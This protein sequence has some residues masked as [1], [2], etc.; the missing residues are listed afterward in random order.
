MQPARK[1]NQSVE[2]VVAAGGMPRLRPRCHLPAQRGAVAERLERRR[3]RG[4]RAAAGRW[5]CGGPPRMDAHAGVA[6]IAPGQQRRARRAAHR[7]VGV[8][9]GEARALRRQ[10]VEVRRAEIGRAHARQVA[11]A[12]VVGE[13]DDEVGVRHRAVPCPLRA[14]PSP[15]AGTCC[16]MRWRSA[17]AAVSAATLL[18]ERIDHATNSTQTAKTTA[19]AIAGRTRSFRPAC[20]RA[21][22][23]LRKAERPHEQHQR[24]PDA[25]RIA[26]GRSHLEFRRLCR[27]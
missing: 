2:A 9:V 18:R 20:A 19:S 27:S 5:R 22:K 10:A 23:V 8:P 15:A 24:K 4:R 25:R 11:I 3:Q 13:E 7:R 1:P 16:S 17:A 6:G 21:S 26:I 12:L 14:R